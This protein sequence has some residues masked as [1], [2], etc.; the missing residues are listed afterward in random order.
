MSY[1][2]W[3]RQTTDK[4]LFPDIEWSKPVQK[5]LAGRLGIVGGSSLGFAGVGDSFRAALQTGIGEVKVILPDAL[6]KTVPS[7][8]TDV[9]FAP[10]NPSGGLSQKSFTELMALGEIVDA[11]LLVGDAGRNSE[12]AILYEQFAEKYEKNLIITRDA[13]DLLKNNYEQVVNR[14]NTT[15]VISFAQLQKI[16]RAVYYPKVLTFG[17]NLTQLVEALHK[18]TISY[19][20]NIAVLHKDSLIIASDG[21]VTTTPW[22][23]PMQIWRGITATKASVYIAWNPTKPLESITTSLLAK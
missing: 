4:P 20:I 18:F 10:S 6:K 5:S 15:L 8:M 21:R 11:V 17:M 2:Y 16:F 19:P 1:D 7:T 14:K 9:I 23:N 22:D 13:V 12:T 3:Q